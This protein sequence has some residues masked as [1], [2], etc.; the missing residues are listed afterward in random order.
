MQK[1]LYLTL[2]I[3]CL[4]GCTAAEL[5]FNQASLQQLVGQSQTEVIRKLGQPDKNIVKGNTTYL[6]YATTYENYVPPTAQTYLNPGELSEIGI[7][8]IMGYY[9]PE[10]CVTSFKIQQSVVR[11]VQ[12]MGN[13][14]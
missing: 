3:G 13:C 4:T 9:T 1:Y 7:P 8:G 2:M 5:Q 12:T 10:T 11:N 6:V 14:L